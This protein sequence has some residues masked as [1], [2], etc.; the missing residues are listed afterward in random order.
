M[1]LLNILILWMIFDQILKI[2]IKKR[3][4]KLLMVFDD[5][6]SYV[7]SDKKAQ[8]IFKRFIYWI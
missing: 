3:R 6:I 4:R 2:I 7:M 5:M 8:I 1:F